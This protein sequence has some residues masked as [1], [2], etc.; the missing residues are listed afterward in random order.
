MKREEPTRTVTCRPVQAPLLVSRNK[1][2]LKHGHT[3]S[4][5]YCLH[6]CLQVLA[7]LNQCGRNHMAQKAKN[8]YYLALS[9]ESLPAPELEGSL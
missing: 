2:L 5:T 9:G 8:S 1:I 4:F 6:G 3:P 7:E